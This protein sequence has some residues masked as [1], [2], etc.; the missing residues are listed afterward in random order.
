[1]LMLIYLFF[2]KMLIYL[3]ERKNMFLTNMKTLTILISYNCV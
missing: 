2:D 3:K 1:M